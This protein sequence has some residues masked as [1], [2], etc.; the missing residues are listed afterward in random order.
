MPEDGDAQLLDQQVQYY[1]ARAVEYDEWFLREGRYD[2]GAEHRAEWFRE[3]DVVR[4]ALVQALPRGN[5]L[6][7]ACGTGLWTRELSEHHSA[8]VA[9]D[10]SPETIAINRTRV[11]SAAVDYIVADLF[12]W[13]PPVAA[14]DAVFFGFWLSHVPPGR[15][16]AFWT[17]VRRALKPAGRVFFVDSQ[18]EPTST[19][20]D[21]AVDDSGVVRR[22]LN[23]GREFDIVK[24]FYDPARLEQRLVEQGWQGWVRSTGKFFLYGS[25]WLEQ[26]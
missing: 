4:S 16:D 17:S 26:G 23:D 1:R 15:F 3:V 10:A 22:R 7:L 2:R 20:R 21:H 18:L 19:A 14:F 6:E 11:Q 8:V 25:L 5:V 12:A 24:V 9:V 13:A